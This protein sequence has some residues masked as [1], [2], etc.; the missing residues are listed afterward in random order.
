[1]AGELGFALLGQRQA[2]IGFSLDRCR[3]DVVVLGDLGLHYYGWGIDT[4]GGLGALSHR[5]APPVRD[6][7]D[8]AIARTTSP[9]NSAERHTVRRV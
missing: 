1:M 4:P 5:S 2:L 6:G 7:F 8:L 9:A 3:A